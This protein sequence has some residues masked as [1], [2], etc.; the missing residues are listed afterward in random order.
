MLLI[1]GGVYLENL[2]IFMT[3]I[4]LETLLDMN[5]GCLSVEVQCGSVA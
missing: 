4:E 5:S 2:Q 3:T 1:F